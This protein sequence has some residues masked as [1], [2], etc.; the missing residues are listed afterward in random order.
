MNT[1]KFEFY[2]PS[3]GSDP[4]YTGLFASG[5][6]SATPAMTPLMVDEGTGKLV[7]WDGQKAGKAVTL[8]AMDTDGKDAR[9]TCF[10]SGTWR[11]EEV[12]WPSDIADELKQNAFAGSSLSIA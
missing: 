8:L 6:T 3:A 4:I 12:K 9:I 10:K 1:E 2:Q 5:L 11:K 7:V